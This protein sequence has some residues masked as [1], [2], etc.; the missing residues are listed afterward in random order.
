MILSHMSAAKAQT[1][2]RRSTAAVS[3]RVDKEELKVQC[4]SKH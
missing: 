3:L 4:L 2:L 1:R